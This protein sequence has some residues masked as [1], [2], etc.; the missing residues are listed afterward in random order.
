MAS[1]FYCREAL[2]R[3]RGILIILVPLL[4]KKNYIKICLKKRPKA[5]TR[6][7]SPR[8]PKPDY[9]WIRPR[10][11]SGW[12]LEPPIGHESRAVLAKAPQTG[13][14]R[15]LFVR[16]IIFRELHSVGEP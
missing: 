13:A 9:T 8:P 2:L 14:A 16:L 11:K 1:S 6:T 10:C 12:H 3:A 7:R 15:Q 4:F 5:N